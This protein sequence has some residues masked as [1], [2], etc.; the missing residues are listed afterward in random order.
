MCIAAEGCSLLL[1]GSLYSAL[2]YQFAAS[3][4]LGNT[5]HPCLY[6]TSK[7]NG[8]SLWCDSTLGQD[9]LRF[10]LMQAWR[11]I[12]RLLG[13]TW[14]RAHL[15]PVAVPTFWNWCL[16]SRILFFS[17]EATHLLCPG[18]CVFP[19]HILYELMSPWEAD[20]IICSNLF[21]LRTGRRRGRRKKKT[22]HWGTTQFFR[23]WCSKHQSFKSKE[24]TIFS[25]DR[26]LFLA[27]W[28]YGWCRIC[29]Y[30]HINSGQWIHH[31][32]ETTVLASFPL[33]LL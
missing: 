21:Q 28:Y 26:S 2:N 32:P 13:F 18:F 17:M 9:H 3:C 24:T 29:I 33:P 23:E 14:P 16:L 1:T 25:R 4:P 30:T 15:T 31:S 12:Q 11:R 8:M 6:S 22:W 20:F 7:A 19:V 10:K 27:S 5:S